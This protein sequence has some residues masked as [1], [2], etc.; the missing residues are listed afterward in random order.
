MANIKTLLDLRRAKTDGTFNII[1][2]ITDHKKVYTINSGV[3]LEEHFWDEKI[4]QVGKI[5]PNAKLLNIKLSTLPI[6]T[7][8]LI[9]VCLKNK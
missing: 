1:F 3:A 4:G 8:A 7:R 2:R 6:F 5:H 9:L